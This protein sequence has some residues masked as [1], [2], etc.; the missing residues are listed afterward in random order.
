MTHSDWA[1]AL[2]RFTLLS[3]RYQHVSTDWL[4]KQ[5]KRLV[6]F[7]ERLA[8]LK[9]QLAKMTQLHQCI[10]KRQSGAQAR[11]PLAIH[12]RLD[13]QPLPMTSDSHVLPENNGRGGDDSGCG[14]QQGG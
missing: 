14:G 7:K 4:A 11:A 6:K 9:K 13:M 10:K 8:A 2:L 12:M 1:G 3:Y 5:T